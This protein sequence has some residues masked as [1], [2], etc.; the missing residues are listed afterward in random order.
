MFKNHNLIKSQVKSC[1]QQIEI[2]NQQTH[3]ARK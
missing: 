1:L 2:P 3:S